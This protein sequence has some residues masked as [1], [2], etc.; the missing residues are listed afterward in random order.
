VALARNLQPGWAIELV[1]R[2]HHLGYLGIASKGRSGGLAGRTAAQ[3]SAECGMVR[4]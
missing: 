4:K 1:M 2:A 3:S